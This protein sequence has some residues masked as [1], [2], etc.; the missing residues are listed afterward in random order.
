MYSFESRIRYSET[1]CE[2]R[3]T[4]PALINYFQDCSTFQAEDVG[5]GF[6]YMKERKQ[7][8]VLASWQID[9]DRYPKMGERVVVGTIPYEIRG[10]FGQRNF[11]MKGEDGSFL[12]KANTLWTL[13]EIETEK[14]RRAA[15]E[16]L[17]CFQIGEKLEMQYEDRKILIPEV[18]EARGQ[19]PVVQ[20]HLDANRHVNNGQYISIAME[21]LPEGLQVK[22]LRAEYRKQAFLGDVMVPYIAKE[23]NR[24]VISI[25]NPEGQCYAVVEFTV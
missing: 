17:D 7:V 21:F 24:Y 18:R 22:R 15:K 14:P 8:W 4:L 25:Q 20:H 6:Q 2:R 9:I 19:I 3:L 11:F 12:A 13:I 1:D 5:V 16:M 23:E 10:F